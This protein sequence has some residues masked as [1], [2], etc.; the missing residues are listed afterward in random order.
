MSVIAKVGEFLNTL[1]MQYELR[2]KWWINAVV[3]ILS[4][5]HCLC[6][7]F[8]FQNI[9]TFL[10]EKLSCA[11]EILIWSDAVDFLIKLLGMPY[12]VVTA[13]QACSTEMV[14]HFQANRN[15]RNLSQG[16][17]THTTSE[18][19]GNDATDVSSLLDGISLRDENASD[20]GA[21]Q[22]VETELNEDTIERTDGA[23]DANT[24]DN[25]VHIEIVGADEGS[26]EEKQQT[27]SPQLGEGDVLPTGSLQESESDDDDDDDSDSDDDGWITPSNIC[28][29]KQSMGEY[30]S[31]EAEMVEVGCLT[32]DFA[33]QVSHVEIVNFTVFFLVMRYRVH[34][35]RKLY[36]YKKV[37]HYFDLIQMR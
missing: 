15:C 35:V 3:M 17:P 1:T 32:T 23:R 28:S 29:V 27:E 16:K 18:S 6:W 13:Q 34:F 11:V 5:P 14:N 9:I 4:V 20:E 30:E 8:Y 24:H 19:E 26:V 7:S 25:V 10:F 22:T 33:M 21:S 36:L 2:Y 31:S 12:S 37:F